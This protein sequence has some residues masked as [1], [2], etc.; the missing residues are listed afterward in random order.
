MA[1]WVRYLAVALMFACLCSEAAAQTPDQQLELTRIERVGRDIHEH[2][3]AA[4]LGTDALREDFGDEIGARLSGWIT[5]REG[6]AITV[7][8][9]TEANDGPHALYRATL[10]DDVLVERGAADAP[11]NPVQTQLF[12]ARQVAREAPFTPCS[13]RYNTV[14]IPAEDGQSA[15]IYLL[16]GTTDPNVVPVGGAHRV[17]VNLATS[18]IVET[19][20]FSRSCIALPFDRQ[21]AALFVT[22]LATPL[23]TETHV[24]ISLSFD[25]PFYIGI[26]GDVWGIEGGQ[27]RLVRR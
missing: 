5:E 10:R 11:L 9:V 6:K 18:A 19:Q 24:F 23:P 22:H 20:A 13:T 21:A 14:T 27:V 3:R 12:R 25:M 1:D 15:D 17:R 8:F 2:D 7:T 4:W 26:G 16:P